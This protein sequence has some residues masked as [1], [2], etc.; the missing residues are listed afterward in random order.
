MNQTKVETISVIPGYKKKNVLYH[1]ALKKELIPIKYMS[2]EEFLKNVTN[3]PKKEAIYY[4]MKDLHLSYA[5]AS[6][7]LE[8]IPRITYVEK[9]THPNVKKLLEIKQYLEDNHLLEDHKIFQKYIQCKQIQI[10]D[11]FLT[12]EQ[13]SIFKHI[14]NEAFV[15]IIESQAEIH[16]HPLYAFDSIEEE[17]SF[18]ASSIA[19]NLKS[20]KSIHQIYL[21]NVTEEYHEPLQRIFHMYEI[22]LEEA[23]EHTLYGTTIVQQWLKSLGESSA[24][25][26]EDIARQMYTEED[27]QIYT[28]LL[29]IYNDYVM[30][31]KDEH[32]KTC[33]IEACKRTSIPMLKKHNAIHIKDLRTD[34]FQEKDFVYI[35]GMNQ[36]NIPKVKKDEDYLNDKI[37]EELNLDTTKEKNAYEKQLL[38][39]KINSIS[40]AVLTYKKKTP[41]RTYYPSS[42]LKKL[43]VEKMEYEPIVYQY[44]D[45]QNR[46]EL[47][48]LLDRYTQYNE[49]SENLDLLYA[50]YPNLP[51]NTYCNQYQPIAKQKLKEYLNGKLTLSYTSLDCFY[52]CGFRY[53]ISNILK[54]DTYEET[55]AQKIGNLFHHFLSIAFQANFD[56]EKE[57]T[58]YHQNKIYTSKEAFFLKKLKQEI[59]FV[60]NTIKEQ[61]T[62]TSLN[63]EE[64]EQKIFKSISGDLK[65][66]FMGIL[67]KIK[68]K[69]DDGVI[70]TAIIDYKTGTLETNLNHSIYGIG[71]QL[72]IYLY[73]LK[74]KPNWNHVKVVG[75]YLQKII[76]N[77]MSNDENKEYLQLKKDNMRLVGYSIDQPSILEKLDETYKNSQMIKSMKVSSKG[78]YAYAKVM[79]EQKMEKLEQLVHKKIEEAAHRISNANFEINPKKIGTQL[80]GCEF[81]TYHDLCFQS[82]RD[83]IYLKE[84]KNL[85]FLEEDV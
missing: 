62:Y 33:I 40:N 24:T 20:G 65:I 23:K 45:A 35:L 79:S 12:K 6:V 18:V 80:V 19:K 27:Y 53:Y 13:K 17:I 38:I 44:A 77:E 73:L 51:Y 78:F 10:E 83:I 43:Q 84:Y 61:N 30:L 4:L 14:Q 39:Q 16:T 82:P 69:E 42:L 37:C 47:A 76:Q 41:F 25:E 3:Q 59:Y 22:P 71:M 72:P 5:L 8:N 31:P 36:E 11:N 60:L 54:L 9:S 56:F 1:Y 58:T 70:Y 2:L 49:R 28:A 74:N 57:W 21:T 64:Y 32:W 7:Y 66:T 34:G 15:T 75:F 52:R 81:C 68:Y 26:L 46:M 48:K 29:E 67:D 55:F 50:H 85:E 63:Q